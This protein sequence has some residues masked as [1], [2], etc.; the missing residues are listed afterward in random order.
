MDAV[1]LDPAVG[2]EWDPK[3]SDFRYGADLVKF[4]RQ[5]FGDY[6]VICVAGKEEDSSTATNVCFRYSLRLSSRSSRFEF[7]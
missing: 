5:H 1:V 4:I 6:F 2:E 7:V 3:K